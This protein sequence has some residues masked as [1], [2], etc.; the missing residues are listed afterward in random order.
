MTGALERIDIEGR[1][2]GAEGLLVCWSENLFGTSDQ[3][4][5]TSSRLLARVLFGA[6][7]Y[8]VSI[9]QHVDCLRSLGCGEGTPIQYN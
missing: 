5:L 1:S 3:C 8:A 9:E 6:E 2:V 4:L 7:Q